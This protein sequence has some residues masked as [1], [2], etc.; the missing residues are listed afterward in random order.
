MIFNMVYGRS[1]SGGG[2][3]PYNVA[4]FAYTN[5]DSSVTVTW[6]DTEDA[7]W[8]GTVVLAKQGS[9]PDGSDDPSA[10]VVV[11]SKVRSQYATEGYTKTGF[12]EGDWFFQAYPYSQ[13]GDI[14]D[15]VVNRLPVTV[16]YIYPSPLQDF[17]A[18]P[19]N[20]SVTLA[21]TLPEDAVGVDVVYKAGGYPASQADG[22][23]IANAQSGHVVGGL[24]NDTTYFFRAFPKNAYGRVNTD[25]AG[26]QAE[27]TPRERLYIF[28]SGAG[29]SMPLYTNAQANVSLTLDTTSIKANIITSG[30]SSIYFI[31]RTEE[32]VDIT[33]YDT[34]VVE[35]A[36]SRY[37]ANS[38]GFGIFSS[39]VN[40]TGGTFAAYAVFSAN[41]TRTEYTLDISSFSGVY[42]VGINVAASIEVFNIY[43]IPKG[44]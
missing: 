37:V 20:G 1:G 34:L 44:V 18:S 39:P 13:D 29:E 3:Y 30:T 25:T 16:A 15:N 32:G 40:V 41:N 14:S 43:L 8:A 28:Q 33:E 27:A 22:T 35:G 12:A 2:G 26:N 23:K 19:G 11:D 38:K 24:V 7:D 42:Y 21:F 10:M 36:C 9:Y 17:K 6:R 31:V 4:D 5:E